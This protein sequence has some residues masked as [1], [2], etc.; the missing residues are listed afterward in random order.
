MDQ[1]RIGWQIKVNLES[2]TRSEGNYHSLLHLDRNSKHPTLLLEDKILDQ[3]DSLPL[4]R[5]SH[6]L[7]HDLHR[8]I[9]FQIMI[10][11]GILLI[12]Y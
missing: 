2:Q 11:Y 12:I 9:P 5:N 1:L 10:M 3:R 6:C 4:L 7:I 8:Q